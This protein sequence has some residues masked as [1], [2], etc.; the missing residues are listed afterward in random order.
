MSL[1]SLLTSLP[2]RRPLSGAVTLMTP[3]GGLVDFIC[4]NIYWVHALVYKLFIFGKGCLM[5]L[6]DLIFSVLSLTQPSVLPGKPVPCLPRLSSQLYSSLSQPPSPPC[7]TE[8]G[9]S[10]TDRKTVGDTYQKAISSQGHGSPFGKSVLKLQPGFLRKEL[11]P[12]RTQA[13]TLSQCK[14]G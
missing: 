7:V 2:G 11:R 1:R 6:G 9:R 10:Q 4:E 8:H 14:V 3:A 12:S 5:V 13:L